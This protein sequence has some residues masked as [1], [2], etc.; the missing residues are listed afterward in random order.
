MP[1]ILVHPLPPPHRNPYYPE[2]PTFTTSSRA[3]AHFFHSHGWRARHVYAPAPFSSVSPSPSVSKLLS[4]SRYSSLNA[5]HTPS[6]NSSKPSLHRPAAQS[7]DG[8]ES[9]CCYACTGNAVVSCAGVVELH[10]YG[11]PINTALFYG[12]WATDMQVAYLRYYAW[13]HVEFAKEEEV[14]LRVVNR[15]VVSGEVRGEQ[16]EMVGDVIE[17]VDEDLDQD[18]DEVIDE[19]LAEQ[20]ELAERALLATGELEWVEAGK[21]LRKTDGS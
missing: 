7:E 6:T 4:T 17:V 10:D 12:P 20:W 1:Y 11:I 9:A 5:S 19:E 15:T 3:I 16:K 21:K 13:G 2:L 8:D 14:D 18:L